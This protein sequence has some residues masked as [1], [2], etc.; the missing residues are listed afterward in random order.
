MY[1]FS[2]EAVGNFTE[3][4][5]PPTTPTPST[6]TTT[7]KDNIFS[8]FNV[9]GNTKADSPEAADAGSDGAGNFDVGGG[10]GAEGSHDG[11]G[12]G[13]NAWRGSDEGSRKKCL[14]RENVLQ[15]SF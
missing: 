9:D 7:K 3:E 11:K 13:E 2:A 1:V 8:A 15:F 5:P 14:F 12:M 4:V 6:T 10:Q